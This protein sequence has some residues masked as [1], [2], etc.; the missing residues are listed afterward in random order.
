M[1]SEAVQM[2]HAKYSVVIWSEDTFNPNYLIK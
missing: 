2:V 1:E